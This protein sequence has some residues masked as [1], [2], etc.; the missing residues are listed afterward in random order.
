VDYPKLQLAL[1]ITLIALVT[2]QVLVWL[3]NT[4]LF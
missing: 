2:A 4:G 1:T 3:D